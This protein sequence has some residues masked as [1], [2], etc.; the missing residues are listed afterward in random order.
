MALPSKGEEIDHDAAE[1]RLSHDLSKGKVVDATFRAH[2]V[3]VE[4]EYVS[5]VVDLASR[6]FESRSLLSNW[7][8]DQFRETP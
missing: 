8:T 3:R 2:L 5:S 1:T 4:N 6:F 7:I